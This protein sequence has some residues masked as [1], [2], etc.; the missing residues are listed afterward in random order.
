MSQHEMWNS[1]GKAAP[2]TAGR[3]LNRR[4]VMKLAGSAAAG[5]A[6]T[7]TGYAAAQEATPT[8]QR[9]TVY[10]GRN[11]NLVG[12]LIEQFTAASGIDVDVR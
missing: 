11:E 5:A 7:S 10:S 12:P 9:L 1:A 4:T 3:R 6:V 2:M 8:G